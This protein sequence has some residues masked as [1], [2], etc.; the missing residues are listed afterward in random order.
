MRD[1]SATG[2]L[3]RDHMDVIYFITELVYY[4]KIKKGNSHKGIVISVKVTNELA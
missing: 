3:L 4:I 2:T 1:N